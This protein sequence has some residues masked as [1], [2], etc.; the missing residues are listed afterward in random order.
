MS[1]SGPNSWVY[2]SELSPKV[3]NGHSI[4]D[5]KKSSTSKLLRGQ[6]W[7]ILYGDGSG[8]EGDVFTDIVTIGS[9]TA[10]NQAI[11][12]ASSISP[13]FKSDVASD[14]ILGLGFDFV[15]QVQPT[16]Q[17]TFFSNVKDKLKAPLF[18]AD[19][20]KGGPGSYDFGFIDDSKH[21]KAITY[22]DADDSRGFWGFT[23]TGYAVGG[24]D[25]V[26]EE[27]PAIMDTGTSLL[28]LPSYVVEAYYKQ[29]PGAEYNK[30]AG[31]WTIP[32][33]SVPPS[34]AVGVGSY[35]ASIPGAFI[36]YGPLLN[37]NKSMSPLFTFH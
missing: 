15:N 37:D 8:A 11:E 36:N 16:K 32:C 31:G 22:V 18:T 1:H 7:K 3:R 9:T 33:T 14:G 21:T 23:C 29:V 34:F 26:S 10:T 20:K 17:K 27:I 30:S 24:A 13:A 4:Y 2:S 6:Y 28:L 35:E 25:P 19:L 12:A 5:P